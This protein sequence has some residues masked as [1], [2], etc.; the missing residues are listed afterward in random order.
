MDLCKVL[1]VKQTTQKQLTTAEED[2]A[3]RLRRNRYLDTEIDDL[4][5]RCNEA[6]VTRTE[7]APLLI[8]VEGLKVS[9]HTNLQQ[10]DR[11]SDKVREL[12]VTL[13]G[14]EAHLHRMLG[15]P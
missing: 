10:L 7:S 11:I 5:S 13:S 3:R 14:I 12:H 1:L 6:V 15:M 2:V 4:L 9:K 8:K